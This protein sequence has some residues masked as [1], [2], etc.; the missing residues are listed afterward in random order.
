MSRDGKGFRGF[1]G[2]DARHF[3]ISYKQSYAS[4]V[5]LDMFLMETPVRTSRAILPKRVNMPETCQKHA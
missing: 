3:E 2:G 5:P 4:K 1:D